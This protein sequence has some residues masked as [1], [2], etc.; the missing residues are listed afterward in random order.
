MNSFVSKLASPVMRIF[1]VALFVFGTCII[2]GT[3]V[4]DD[5]GG[6]GPAPAGD[7][8]L[9]NGVCVEVNGGC[10]LPFPNCGMP[11]GQPD[12]ACY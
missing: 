12:C 4:A 7:C 11:L 10:P 5:P 3:V 9:V 2:C 6:P 1:G 8:I